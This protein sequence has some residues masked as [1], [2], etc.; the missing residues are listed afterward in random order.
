MIKIK[1]VAVGKVKEEYFRAAAAEYFKR[2]SRFCDFSCEEVKEENFRETDEATKE[3][4]LRTEG[5]R[6][7]RAAK[8]Y[9]IC[10]AVEG[11][12]TTSEG[13]AAKIKSLSDAGVGE[14]TFILGGSYGIDEGVKKRSDEL[15]SFSDMTFP[16]TL[17][18]VMA[19]EQ[20]YRAFSIINGNGYHK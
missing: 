1:L 12:K 14:I 3:K 15:T 2:L 9:R 4:I 10:F 17:A 5:E 6:I 19:A 18:R 16:H 8:G 20:I 13:L 7:E 11:K